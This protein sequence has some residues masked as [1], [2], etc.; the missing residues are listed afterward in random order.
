MGKLTK[1]KSQ[2]RKYAIIIFCALVAAG[3]SYLIFF[4]YNPERNALGAFST[5][6]M[7]IICILLLF[8]F[9][10]GQGMDSYGLKRTSGLFAELLMATLL[11]VFFDLVNWSFDGSLAFGTV[12]FW[13]TVG[14]L[15]MGP[16]MAGFFAMYICSYM[17]EVHGLKKMRETAL[18]CMG[19]NIFSC[20]L[21]FVLA[22]IGAAF[23]FVDGHY[24]AGEL[25]DVLFIIPFLTLLYLV[26]VI[27]RYRKTIGSHDVVAVVGYIFLLLAG[28]VVES[29]FFIGTTYVSVV[30]AD[31]FIYVMLQNVIIAREKS[32]TLIWM[33]RSKL[34]GLTGLYN[35]CAYEDD[36]MRLEKDVP[37]DA[38][39]YIS[40]DV[41]AL[42]V[43]NDSLGH[44]AGDEIITGAA[45]ILK[46]CFGSYGDL[47]RT[48][49]DEFVALIYAD[50]I[51]LAGMLEDFQR[52]TEAWSGNQVEKLSISYGYIMKSENNS[53]SVR[54]MA[55][56]AD[57][58]MYKRKRAFYGTL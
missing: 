47:F 14:S 45:D 6:C 18:V 36:M 50:K 10:L 46:K 9:L 34:D 48:G 29:I 1:Y 19:L 54:Q 31:V 26:C 12:P 23:K 15:C 3:A 27:L 51:Q 32:N 55:V 4:C 44:S 5:V 43:V 24:E 57:E 16:V 11:A 49:G 42:K 25:Y 39:V 58:R 21:S 7:D 2:I 33:E 17:D 56:L 53:L 41:N 30:I 37:S 28:A 8:V 35:R 22:V 38:F 52:L 13:F 40:M 20:A